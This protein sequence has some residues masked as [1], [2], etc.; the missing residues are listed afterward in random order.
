MQVLNNGHGHWLTV[1]TIA[2]VDGIIN[3]YDSLCT[4]TPTEEIKKQV[5]AI[6]NSKH[7]AITLKYINVQR[8]SATSNCGLFALAFVM[9]LLDKVNPETKLYDQ[10]LMRQHLLNALKKLPLFFSIMKDRKIRKR[11][12]SFYTVPL[13]CTCRMAKEG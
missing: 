8:Q 2:T 13:Y 3:V 9:S 10:K 12:M 11:I 6:V 7:K 4:C 1:S 5:A